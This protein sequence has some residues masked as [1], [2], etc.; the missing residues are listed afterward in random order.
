MRRVA[1]GPCPEDLERQTELG[2]LRPST[3]THAPIE[4]TA[5][6]DTLVRHPDDYKVVLDV[7]RIV[8]ANAE[9]E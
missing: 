8:C 6:A 4:Q 9:S 2:A 7:I 5:L 1:G 3:P